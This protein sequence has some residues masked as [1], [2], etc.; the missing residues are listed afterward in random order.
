MEK[1]LS[2]QEKT[3]CLNP[4]TGGSIR[5]DSGTYRLFSAAIRHVLKGNKKM[6][7]AELAKSVA[8]YVRRK[9]PGFRGSV[10]WYTIVV[11]DDLEARDKLISSMEKGKKLNYLK[12]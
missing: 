9:D 4:R 2:A 11:K 8:G 10:S 7:F 6:A 5:I 1:S 3:V 12:P